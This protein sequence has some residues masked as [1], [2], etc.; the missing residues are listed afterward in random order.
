MSAPSSL[1]RWRVTDRPET[2]DRETLS[3]SRQRLELSDLRADPRVDRFTWLDQVHGSRVVTVVAPGAQCG[4]VADAAVTDVPQAVL[5]IRSADCAPLLFEGI[6][7][8]RPPVDGVPHR[9][10]DGIADGVA[11][12]GGRPVLGVA[13]AGWRGLLD[14]V[15]PRTVD[16]MRAL[17]AESIVAWLGPCIGP[18]CYEFAAEALGPLRSAFGPAVESRTAWGSVALDLPAAVEAAVEGS[19]V[20]FGSPL[21]G[22]TCTACDARRYSHRSRGEVGRMALIAQIRA[23]HVAEHP[24]DPKRRPGSLSDAKR[25][26]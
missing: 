21:A 4:V 15:V 23:V 26:K 1:V 22:W 25:R 12:G 5:V 18:E 11:D 16:A 8:Q 10:A 20:A 14:G 7:R 19:G 3:R 9:V 24:S 2:W 13:H 17:G 6:N